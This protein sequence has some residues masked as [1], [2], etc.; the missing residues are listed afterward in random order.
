MTLVVRQLNS[1]GTGI[2]LQVYAFANTIA[3]PD[4]EM[5]QSDIFDH[6]YSI[7]EEFE[8]SIFQQPTGDDIRKRL[9]QT[10]DNS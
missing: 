3:F 7:V 4:Y 8:L 1:T 5:V 10:E 2:P 6:F 9:I